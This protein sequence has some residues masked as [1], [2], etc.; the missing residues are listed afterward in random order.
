MV[1][2]NHRTPRTFIKEGRASFSPTRVRVGATI[3]A[4][5]V[6]VCGIEIGEYAFVAAG[7]VV[8]KSV[9]AYGFVAGNPARLQGYVCRCLKTRV[10]SLQGT[11]PA[12]CPQCSGEANR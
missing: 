8:T 1:F 4:G 7:A 2:T 11:G 3:G 5:A 12:L 9:P 6:L 10:R